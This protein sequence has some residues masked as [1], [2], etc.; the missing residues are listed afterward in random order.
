MAG[1]FSFRIFTIN[2]EAS[3]HP[4]Y[5]NISPSLF[6]YISLIILIRNAPL[7]IFAHL[8]A[9]LEPEGSINVFVLWKFCSNF[10]FQVKTKINRTLLNI[11][12]RQVIFS[13]RSNSFFYSVIMWLAL[14]QFIQAF[15]VSIIQKTCW[16]RQQLHCYVWSSR[17]NP[18]KLFPLIRHNLSVFVVK[19]GHLIVWCIFSFITNTQA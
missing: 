14:L 12:S 11:V 17:A 8:E 13:L 2:F 4:P 3:K 6:S 18:N 16:K 7:F 10:F 9:T 1:L 15:H 5:F 19:L